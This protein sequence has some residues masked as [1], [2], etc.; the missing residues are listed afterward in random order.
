MRKLMEALDRI[1]EDPEELRRDLQNPQWRERRADEQKMRREYLNHIAKTGEEDD[2]RYARVKTPR[3]TGT[4]Y[5][6]HN[7]EPSETYPNFLT[8]SVRKFG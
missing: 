1:E 6:I 4:I 7:L 3:G 8:V 5:S 2:L